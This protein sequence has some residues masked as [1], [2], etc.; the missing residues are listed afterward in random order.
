MGPESKPGIVEPEFGSLYL[1]DL[2]R[3]IEK[4]EKN[5]NISNGLAWTKDN[6]TMFYIDSTPR[7]VYAYDYD[8]EAGEISE[9]CLLQ[10]YKC[11]LFSIQVFERK[12]LMIDLN[13]HTILHVCILRQLF[14]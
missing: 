2:E 12:G 3:N 11:V 1:L 9:L 14:F 4:K 7:K 8:V 10:V 6:K 5:I 13:H